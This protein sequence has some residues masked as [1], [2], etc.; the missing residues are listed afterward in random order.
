MTETQSQDEFYDLLQD[1]DILQTID[2]L[3]K[4]EESFEL[5][6]EFINFSGRIYI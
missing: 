6:H 1:N 2:D 4:D 5:G 3:T